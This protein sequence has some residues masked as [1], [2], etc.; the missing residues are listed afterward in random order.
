MVPMIGMLV[1]S[2]TFAAP[3]F[4]LAL[5]PRLVEKL[6]KGGGLNVIKVVLGF[7]E[8]A[9][10]F[11]FISN[12]DLV[13]NGRDNLWLTFELNVAIWSAIK[14]PWERWWESCCSTGHWR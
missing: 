10:A 9:A 11:K 2:V 7:I 3:F 4:F 14:R 13:V 5:F 1:Y 12:W 6:P 8:L